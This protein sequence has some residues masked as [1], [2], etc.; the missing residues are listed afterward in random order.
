MLLLPDSLVSALR[1]VLGAG[2]GCRP[3]RVGAF[4]VR[5]FFRIPPLV[6]RLVSGAEVPPRVLA[7]LGAIRFLFWCMFL[8]PV[9]WRDIETTR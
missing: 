1:G 4:R 7:L 2:S 5:G 8:G 3:Y 6:P 9:R